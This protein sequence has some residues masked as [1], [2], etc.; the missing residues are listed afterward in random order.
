MKDLCITEMPKN[1]SLVLDVL[2]FTVLGEKATSKTIYSSVIDNDSRKAKEHLHNR[3]LET[4]KPV[5]F[6]SALPMLA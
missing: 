4:S 5:V 1:L 3:S 6:S 2:V